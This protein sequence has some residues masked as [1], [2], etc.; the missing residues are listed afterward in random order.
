MNQI[1]EKVKKI[2]NGDKVA[3]F[4][5]WLFKWNYNIKTIKE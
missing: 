1:K 3:G 2:V 5:H 4:N